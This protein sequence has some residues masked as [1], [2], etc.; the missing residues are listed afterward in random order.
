MGEDLCEGFAPLDCAFRSLANPMLFGDPD[1]YAVRYLGPED[2]GGVHIN[3]GIATHA[4]YLLIEGGTNR[5]SGK[6]VVGLGSDRRGD[7]ERIFYL[8][9]TRYLTPAATFSDARAATVQAAQELFG[10]GSDE[11]LRT[12]DAWTAVGV[13]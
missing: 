3:C 10:A 2:Y 13:E 8:A 6:T 5:V 4:F 1:H 9:F 11:M 12:A 7:A